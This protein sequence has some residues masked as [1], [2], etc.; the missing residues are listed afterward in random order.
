MIA[1]IYKSHDVLHN[2]EHSCTTTAK[3]CD[4]NYFLMADPIDFNA[5]ILTFCE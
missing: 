2:I 4:F 5:Q 1:D 3:N